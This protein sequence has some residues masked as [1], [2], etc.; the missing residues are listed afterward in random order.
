[1]R[2]AALILAVLL[3]AVP[4]TDTGTGTATATE[5]DLPAVTIEQETSE[6]ASCRQVTQTPATDNGTGTVTE[7]EYQPPYVEVVQT[8]QTE[9]TASTTVTYDE[10]GYTAVVSP[11]EINMIAYLVDKE[12]GGGTRIEKQAVVWC[13]LNRVDK[14]R[15]GGFRDTVYG[16]LT[17]SGQFRSYYG[18]GSNESYNIVCDCLTL[19]QM[20]KQSGYP[21]DGRVLPREFCWYHG[22][23]RHNH[24]RN[25]YSGGSYWDWSWTGGY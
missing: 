15:A 3:T 23:G 2:A 21:V 19:W 18:T 20:E 1:M 4:V 8:E 22:D 10:R 11:Q 14:G 13:V 6:P 5:Y 25:A 24:F 7:Y 9:Q 12:I 17:Q 16:V